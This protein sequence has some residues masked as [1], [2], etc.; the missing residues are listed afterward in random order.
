[1]VLPACYTPPV[2]LG[3]SHC[4][5]DTFCLWKVMIHLLQ[6]FVWGVVYLQLFCKQPRART[7]PS[8]S[9]V[10]SSI[11]PWKMIHQEKKKKPHTD[12]SCN[13]YFLFFLQKWSRT[14][15]SWTLHCTFTLA[16]LGAA[17]LLLALPAPGADTGPGCYCYCSGFTCARPGEGM[18]LRVGIDMKHLESVH[19]DTSGEGAVC[20]LDP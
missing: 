18:R 12:N 15:Q 5:Y 11:A 14:N 3:T 6:G 19:W 9:R 7:V 10:H 4:Y 20:K 13:A 16:V 8:S 17:R 2:S 1:M